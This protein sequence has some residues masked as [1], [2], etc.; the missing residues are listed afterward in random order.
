MRLQLFLTA[1]IGFVESSPSLAPI[2]IFKKTHRG[3]QA[4]SPA[5][6]PAFGRLLFSQHLSISQFHGL[7]EAD[8]STITYLNEHKSQQRLLA[9]SEHDAVKAAK[10][11]IFVEGIENVRGD[12]SSSFTT[13]LTLGIVGG[14][15]A[16]YGIS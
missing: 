4:E 16:K 6:S 3:Q 15:L 1:L 13:L 9:E 12:S 7:K 2:F 14:V 8:E 5:V 10:L 11:L